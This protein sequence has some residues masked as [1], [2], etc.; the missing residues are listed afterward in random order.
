MLKV[1]D[2]LWKALKERAKSGDVIDSPAVL[3]IIE[4]A[5]DFKWRTG[6]LLEKMIH[7]QEKIL[8][9][10]KKEVVLQREHLGRLQKKI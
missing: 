6:I 2:S 5:E 9:N 10:M 7:F 3:D 1:G 4:A 8:E